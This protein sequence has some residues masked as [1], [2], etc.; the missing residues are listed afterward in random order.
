MEQLVRTEDM[1]NANTILIRKPD[2]RGN[3]GDEETGYENVWWIQLAKKKVQTVRGG[4]GGC[5]EHDYELSCAGIYQLA[6][7]DS[8]SVEVFFF[9][10]QGVKLFL[11]VVLGW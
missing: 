2:R 1:R 4:G 6:Q 11:Y 3:L 9:N 5:S 8:R 10:E 7:K